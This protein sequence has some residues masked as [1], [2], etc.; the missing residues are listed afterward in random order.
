MT[1]TMRRT[2]VALPLLLLA[3]TVAFLNPASARLGKIGAMGDSLT[4]EYW[5]NGGSA[6]STYATNWPQLLVSY[7]GFDMGPT[8]AQAGTNSWGEPR[9]TGYKYNWA[10]SGATSASLL[11]QGQHTGLSAQVASDGVAYAVLAIGPNDFNPSTSTYLNIYY[12]F[13]S[14]SQIQNY[15]NQTVSNIETALATAKNAGISVVLANVIDPGPTPAASSIFTSASNRERVAAAVR[16]VNAGVKNLAQKYQVPLMDWYA[17]ETAVLG[18]NANLHPALKLGNVTINLRGSDPGP[19]NS[20][21]T[22]AFVSDGFHPNTVFQ[23]VFADIVLQAFDSGYAAGIPLLTEQEILNHALI[24]YGGSDTLQSQIGAY[25]NYIILPTLPRI[26]G[27]NVSGTNVSVA[28]STVSNQTYILEG[29]DTLS[30]GPWATV[31]NN[32]PGT[33]GIVSITNRVPANLPQRFYR[34]RQLP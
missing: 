2:R 26:T 7:R 29:R 1:A 8:T 34:V 25:S 30:P 21:P 33:G 12:G 5:D 16:S 31:T 4:D 14:S 19:P 3:L 11:S 15:V 20:A 6:V 24:A 27:I 23:G 13:W 18:P 28:F 9:N 17:L 32:F 10:R 22:N